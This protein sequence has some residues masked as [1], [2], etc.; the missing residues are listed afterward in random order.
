M[1]SLDQDIFNGLKR[2]VYNSPSW[3]ISIN[4]EERDYSITM[5]DICFVISIK[6]RDAYLRAHPEL[7]DGENQ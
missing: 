1:E 5:N 2:W 3:K 6:L 7:E 4:G